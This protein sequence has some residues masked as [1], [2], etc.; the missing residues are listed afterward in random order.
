MRYLRP[1]A[2]PFFASASA[3]ARSFSSLRCL[4]KPA[5]AVADVRDP[6]AFTAGN[7]RFWPVTISGRLHPDEMREHIERVRDQL[8]AEAAFYEAQGESST[9]AYRPSRRAAACDRN[10]NGNASV[11]GKQLRLQ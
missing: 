10:G 2:A 6:S 8:W 5:C 1:R 7:W 9:V 11:Q 3:F 4:H